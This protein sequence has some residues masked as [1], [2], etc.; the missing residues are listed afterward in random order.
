MTKVRFQSSETPVI[1]LG[2][3]YIS[4]ERAP[5]T[6]VIVNAEIYNGRRDNSH[7]IDNLGITG[8]LVVRMTQDFQD[9]NYIVFTNRFYTTLDLYEYLLTKGIGACGTAMTNRGYFLSV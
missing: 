4:S 5:K 6:C 1:L 2:R 7:E 3:L 8:N 9:Q